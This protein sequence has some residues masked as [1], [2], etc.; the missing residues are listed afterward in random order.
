MSEFELDK[1]SIFRAEKLSSRLM[2]DLGMVSEEGPRADRGRELFSEERYA[3][4]A[5]GVP[6][7]DVVANVGQMATEFA[8]ARRWGGE[9]LCL[10]LDDGELAPI[11]MAEFFGV[12]FWPSYSPENFIELWDRYD[13]PFTFRRFMKDAYR[14]SKQQE[15]RVMLTNVGEA[16]GGVRR[17]LNGFLSYRFA[18]MKLWGEWIQGIETHLFG[19][20]KGL[21]RGKGSGGSTPPPP[22]VGPGGGLQVQVSCLT[23]GLRIHVSPAYFINWVF[24][25]CPTTPVASYVLPGRYVFSGDGPMMPKRKK[26]R[27]VFSIPPTYHPFLT[28]F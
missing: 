1:E 11:S 23:P 21:F 18:G 14:R 27:G 2:E 16:K 12:P 5:E 25:G 28:R 8:M 20:S 13:G 9:I 22:A 10:E 19:E 26:D 3:Q 24:F 15:E 4:Q 6:I 17:S 7:N